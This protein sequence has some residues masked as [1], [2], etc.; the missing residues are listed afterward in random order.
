MSQKRGREG[1]R[2]RGKSGYYVSPEEG[3]GTT[4]RRVKTIVSVAR[5]SHPSSISGKKKGGKKTA[6]RA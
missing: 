3:E 1:G 2:K 4:N 6:L 5:E